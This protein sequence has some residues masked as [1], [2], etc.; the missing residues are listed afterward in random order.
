MTDFMDRLG[1]IGACI[2]V[3]GY[4]ASAP[5]GMIYWGAKGWLLGVVLSMILPWFG[6]VSALLSVLA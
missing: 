5:L 2:L 6:G 3:L 4:I 1:G